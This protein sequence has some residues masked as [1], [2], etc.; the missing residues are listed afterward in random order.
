M[1]EILDVEDEHREQLRVVAVRDRY[2]RSHP[3]STP[4]AGAIET[5]DLFTREWS[6]DVHFAAYSPATDPAMRLSHASLG[7]LQSPPQM[8]LFVVDVDPP[9]HV[10]TDAWRDEMHVRAARLPDRPFGFWTKNGARLVWRIEPSSIERPATWA[11]WYLWQLAGIAAITGIVAD[12][13][14]A[15]WTRLHRAPHACRDGEALACGWLCGRPTDFGVWRGV[16]LTDIER[17]AALAW[18]VVRSRAWS[19]VSSRLIEPPRPRPVR[20]TY[21]EH[22]RA[23]GWATREVERSSS[24]MRNATLYKVA[25]W[26]RDKMPEEAIH[27]ELSRAAMRVGLAPTEARRTITSALTARSAS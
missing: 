14:C 23:L 8:V 2:A 13:F 15:D 7:T 5:W 12:P 25:R 3:Q 27:A 11:E 17:A 9:G 22:A 19:R 10:A 18:L 6:T 16:D 21:D 20:D 26:L 1:T 4:A 24:G